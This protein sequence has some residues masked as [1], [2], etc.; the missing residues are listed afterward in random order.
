MQVQ[1][2]YNCLHLRLEWTHSQR[3]SASHRCYP[4]LRTQGI[5][6]DLS[7]TSLVRLLTRDRNHGQL[8]DNHLDFVRRQ[9]TR[10]WYPCTPSKRWK[11]KRKA[12]KMRYVLFN[13]IIR[14]IGKKRQ[15][16]L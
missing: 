6:I 2:S 9:L 14:V 16:G 7:M 4:L 12:G 11:S 3:E 15:V 10:Q 5:I 8:V 1:G 13:N